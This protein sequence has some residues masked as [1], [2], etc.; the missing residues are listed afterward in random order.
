MKPEMITPCVK[1][2]GPY[3]HSATIEASQFL[4]RSA[5]WSA[6]LPTLVGLLFSVVCAISCHSR[7]NRKHLAPTATM[8]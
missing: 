8:N 6:K 4:L 1:S 3:L 5:G 7:S 2:L